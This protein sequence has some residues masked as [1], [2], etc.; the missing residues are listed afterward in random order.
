MCSPVPISLGEYSSDAPLSDT[1]ALSDKTTNFRRKM[2]NTLGMQCLYG[3]SEIVLL[4]KSL[5]T[6]MSLSI[7]VTCSLAA[8]VL[9]T[10]Q[11]LKFHVHQAHLD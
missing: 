1:N 4:L 2:M 8:V 5:I 10:F 9:Y 3:T 6:L 11:R 7:S